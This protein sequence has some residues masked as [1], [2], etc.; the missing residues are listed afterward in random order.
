MVI[1]HL[2]RRTGEPYHF[3]GS[4]LC[5]C[6]DWVVGGSRVSIVLSHA[7]QI[8]A[9][10]KVSPVILLHFFIV[11]VIEREFLP[12]LDIAR[13]VQH[14]A[15]HESLFFMPLQAHIAHVPCNRF[16]T[17]ISCLVE[18]CHLVHSW[19]VAEDRHA[20][21]A[22]AVGY[23]RMDRCAI[24]L[25]TW[26]HCEQ[27]IAS[28]EVDL[29]PRDVKEVRETMASRVAGLLHDGSAP[30]QQKLPLWNRSPCEH[31]VHFRSL[32]AQLPKHYHEINIVCAAIVP[33]LHDHIQP[34]IQPSLKKGA[35]YSARL[36]RN[37][38]GLR[39]VPTIVFVRFGE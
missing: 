35:G 28:F 33:A 8:I 12:F 17:C 11:G 21:I 30:C 9:K 3:P 26:A 24:P 27:F 6:A 15:P 19:L 18:V 25:H 20:T 13:G 23:R 14:D 37:R 2:G 4:Q 16:M 36:G 32:A 34:L 1:R 29:V 31:T 5:T 22:W 39:Q 38:M 7:L 10:L